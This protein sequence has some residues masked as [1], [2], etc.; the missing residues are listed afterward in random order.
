MQKIFINKYIDQKKLVLSEFYD[1]VF[2]FSQLNETKINDISLKIVKN[3]IEHKVGSQF[4]KL[5]HAFSLTSKEGIVLMCLAE[6]LLRI[7]DTTTINDLIEDKIPMGDWK[8]Y[9]K[10][11]RDLFVNISSIAFLLTGKIVEEKPDEIKG[12]LRK[13]VKNLS[14]PLLRS[15]VKQAINILAKQFIF[16]KDINNAIKYSDAKK[17]SKYTFS[18]DMLGESAITYEDSELYY[19]QYEDA[20]IATGKSKNS[21]K[22]SISIKLSSL[23]PRYER[24]KIELLKKELFPKAHKLTELGRENKVDIC[25]DA[26]EA[27]RLNLSLFIFKD[28]VE[29]NLID[30]EYSGFGFAVQAYQK[31]AFFVLDWLNKFLK[32]IDKKI[33]IRLVK[34]A[35]WDS[36]IKIAQEQGFIDYPVFTKKFATDISYLACAHKLLDSENIFSQF[37]THNAHSIAYIKTLFENKEFEFQKLH[38]MGDEIYSYLEKDE[39]FRCRVYAPVGGYKDLLPY[40]VR[41]LLENGSNTSFI[42]QLKSENLDINNLIQSPLKKIKKLDYDKIPKPFQIYPD[43]INSKGLDLSE[44]MTIEDLNSVILKNEILAFSIVDGKDLK[45]DNVNDIISPQTGKVIGQKFFANDEIVDNAIKSLKF[46][47]NKWKKYPIEKKIEIFENFANLIEENI[48]EIIKIGA[49]ESGKSIKNLIAEIREAVDFCRYYSNE[50]AHIFKEKIL[51]GPTGELNKYRLIGKGLSLVISPW[52]FPV[53]I[54]IG[55]TVAALITGNVVLTKPAEQSSYAAYY[56]IKLLLKAGLPKEAIALVLGDGALIA[57]KVIADPKLKNVIF[58]GSL[59]TAKIIQANLQKKESIPTFIAE[60]GGLNCMIVDSSALPE[61]VVKDVVL[62]GF[63]SAGQRC[64][65]CRILCVEENVYEKIKEILIG[66]MKTQNMGNPEDLSTD[67]GPV[68]DKKALMNI[69]EHISKFN[70]VYQFNYKES[71]GTF[72]PPTLI[73]LDKITDIKNEIFGPVIHMIKYKTNE[74]DILIDDINELGFGLTLGVHS[75]IDKT[76]NRIVARAEIGNIYINRNMIG[77]VVGVQPFGG[78]EKSGTGPKAGGPE[79]LKRLCHEQSIS[80]NTASMGGN[81]SLLTEVEE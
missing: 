76:I 37:A 40:F 27:D 46:Y 63:D 71:Q 31:R 4:A 6:A 50:A 13:V 59:P 67:I 55:Q 62:S 23:H 42:H 1:L 70:K 72:V 60:T 74:I 17:H 79:Y 77:A 65:A 53:A 29:S 3:A 32:S 66:A 48:I 10:N 22:K 81:A 69:K 52:N 8:K 43:R 5:I 12:V 19:K 58:T 56:I 2:N 75:R 9:I 57:N 73:E 39:K 80:N 11:D 25:F 20:I 47:S 51:K 18:F 45:S 41:R 16:A 36:E 24:N 28:I 14:G 15:A 26:E 21:Q 30:K 33:N 38:G 49:K 34:G 78:Y 68:I 64:S 54:F 7:P 44:E 35:Y 61:H